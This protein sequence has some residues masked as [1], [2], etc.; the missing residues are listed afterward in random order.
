[1]TGRAKAENGHF[2]RATFFLDGVQLEEV[3]LPGEQLHIGDETTV[4][5][6]GGN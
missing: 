5:L 3:F 1:M 2:C 6:R 4:V